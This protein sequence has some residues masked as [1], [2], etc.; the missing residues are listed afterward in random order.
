LK[1]ELDIEKDNYFTTRKNFYDAKGKYGADSEQA[2]SAEEAFKASMQK[3]E[4]LRQ[5][6]ADS[7]KA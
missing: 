1:K 6:M 3:Q 4:T 5:Q 7:V 2:K